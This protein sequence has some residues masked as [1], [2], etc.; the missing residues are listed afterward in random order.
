M[1]AKVSVLLLIAFAF[2]MQMCGDNSSSSLLSPGAK[3][4]SEGETSLKEILTKEVQ[5]TDI[6][7]GKLLI[8]TPIKDTTTVEVIER[9]PNK[10]VTK[11]GRLR[12][13]YIEKGET[14]YF[15]SGKIDYIIMEQK[16]TNGK[17][18]YSYLK[19][20]EGNVK[21]EPITGKSLMEMG[22]ILGDEG[23]ECQLPEDCLAL[24][25]PPPPDGWKWI[26]WKHV[27][28]WGIEE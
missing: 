5:L 13:F 22:V 16:I 25:P 17:P 6:I 1:K 27:C 11:I 4:N 10:I 14:L 2:F 20:L 7:D 18:E 23:P 19:S 9:T 3:F 24:E 8:M 12:D 26:C 21:I 28:R 15:V